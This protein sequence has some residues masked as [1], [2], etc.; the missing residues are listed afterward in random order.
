MTPASVDQDKPSAFE[1]LL[2]NYWNDDSKNRRRMGAW[3]TIAGKGN[4][5]EALVLYH[6]Y[7]RGEE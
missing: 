1:E 3:M 4:K 7:V 5:E 2:D 6:G